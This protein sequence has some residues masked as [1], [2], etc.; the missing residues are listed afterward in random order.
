MLA[1]SAALAGRVSAATAQLPPEFRARNVEPLP[2]AWLRDERDA[3]HDVTIAPAI[4]RSE[5]EVPA[6][7]PYDIPPGPLAR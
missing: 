7:T 3:G 6:V 4:V 1:A 2:A 5:E